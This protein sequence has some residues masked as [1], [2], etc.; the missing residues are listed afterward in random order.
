MEVWEHNDRLFRPGRILRSED[1]LPIKSLGFQI[2]L[3]RFCLLASLFIRVTVYS[4][5][6]PFAKRNCGP[7]WFDASFFSTYLHRN[8]AVTSVFTLLWS[9]SL[10]FAWSFHGC[11]LAFRENIMRQSRC[12]LMTDQSKYKQTHWRDFQVSSY[13]WGWRL[14]FLSVATGCVQ[15]AVQPV[16]NLVSSPQAPAV[17]FWGFLLC[18]WKKKNVAFSCM[19]SSALRCCSSSL[20]VVSN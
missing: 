3:E 17:C 6:D 19:L 14:V 12:V 15:T 7:V 13:T 20:P 10:E 2:T 1:L 5:L 16:R 11:R 18:I 9:N 4:I 8:I